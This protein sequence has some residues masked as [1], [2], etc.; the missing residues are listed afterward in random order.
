MLVYKTLRGLAPQYLADFCRPVSAV[1]GKSGLRSSMRSDLVVVRTTTNIRR[2]SF[3]VSAP[4]AW[5]RLPQDIRNLQ[6]LKSFRSRLK[7][8]LFNYG[9]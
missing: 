3:T 9:N 6:S 4:L 7:T 1:S 2:C 5:N 8:H